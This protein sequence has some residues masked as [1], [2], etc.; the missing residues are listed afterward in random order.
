MEKRKIARC[1]FH[2]GM[3]ARFS[4]HFLPLYLLSSLIALVSFKGIDDKIFV[5]GL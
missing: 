4:F 5:I 3:F 1:L 2:R